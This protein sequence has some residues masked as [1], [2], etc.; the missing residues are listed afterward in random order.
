[1]TESTK[2]H[3]IAR[4]LW[5]AAAVVAVA[6]A[7]AGCGSHGPSA[8]GSPENPLVARSQEPPQNGR[9]NE[10]R[11]QKG[12]ASGQAEAGTKAPNYQQLL[13]RQTSR[14]E[15]RFTP[16]NLVTPARA[17]AILGAPIRP[18]VEAPQGPTCIYSARSGDSFTTIAVQRLRFSDLARQLRPKRVEIPGVRAY[19]AE[20]QST[21]YVPLG[22]GR[23]L[24]V[25]GPCD[26]AREFASAAVKRLVG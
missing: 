20:R 23:V 5:C 15:Q 2:K 7:L 3:T 22:G 16:C 26:L 11:A 21:V 17:R 14:P 19:C 18:P 6:G 8:P 12:K 4:R 10:A 24:T 9:T 13:E 25:G 1:M